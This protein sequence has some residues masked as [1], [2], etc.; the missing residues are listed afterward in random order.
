L[1]FVDRNTLHV[2][3]ESRWIAGELWSHFP[4]KLAR[5]P[6]RLEWQ[7]LIWMFHDIMC[8]VRRLT[9]LITCCLFINWNSMVII[10]FNQRVNKFINLKCTFAF[11]TSFQFVKNAVKLLNF[12]WNAKNC[13]IPLFCENNFSNN[14][15]CW[16]KAQ[17][18]LLFIEFPYSPNLMIKKQWLYNYIIFFLKNILDNIVWWKKAIKG[19]MKHCQ[20][21]RVLKWL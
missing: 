16:S 2:Q 15:K 21:E 1:F 4:S 3:Q 10:D 18:S 6:E 17:I 14:K 19:N 11:R 13:T 7:L 8:K 5:I 12:R 9:I 20:W